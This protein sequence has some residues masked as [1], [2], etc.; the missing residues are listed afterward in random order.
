MAA[1][2]HQRPLRSPVLRAG[3]Y[4]AVFDVCGRN[5]S[6]DILLEVLRRTPLPLIVLP[7]VQPHAR[8]VMLLSPCICAHKMNSP[9]A[10]SIDVKAK[11]MRQAACNRSCRFG[12]IAQQEGR[13][14]L[15]GLSALI[16]FCV[17]VYLA[18]P[19]RDIVQAADT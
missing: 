6:A 3:W 8:N 7:E 5:E 9:P 16:T 12:Y 1:L 13:A 17:Q 2:K 14:V 4:R 15:L 19:K 11:L 18:A 10:C